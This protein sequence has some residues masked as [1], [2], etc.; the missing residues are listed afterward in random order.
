MAA[1]AGIMFI[2]FFRS[3]QTLAVLVMSG[4]VQ[5]PRRERPG[6]LINFLRLWGLGVAAVVVLLT[7]RVVPAALD[8]FTAGLAAAV[9]LESTATRQARVARGVTVL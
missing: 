3:Q 5:Q 4:L 9:E 2:P 1:L 6:P 7:A 8:A